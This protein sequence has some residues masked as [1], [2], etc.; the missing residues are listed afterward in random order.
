MKLRVGRQVVDEVLVDVVD[1]DE[2]VDG[3]VVLVVLLVVVVFAELV[4]LVVV[5]VLVVVIGGMELV[6]V[7]C[8]ELVA[9][10]ELVDE[11]VLNVSDCE[12]AEVD[13]GMEDEVEGRTFEG[14]VV[15]DNVL[16]ALVGV[17]G[18]LVA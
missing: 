4:V 13:D 5:L 12:V 11:T 7:T 15:L 10:A 3:V 9:D 16:D 8:V 14:L 18:L 2:V 17:D 1:C 6:V